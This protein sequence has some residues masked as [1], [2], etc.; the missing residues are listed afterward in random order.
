[1]A[2]IAFAVFFSVAMTRWL[3]REWRR[4]EDLPPRDRVAV[5]RALRRGEDVGERRLA[6]AVIDLADVIRQRQERDRRY[7]WVVWLFGGVMLC[8]AL[9]DSLAGSTRSA[10]PWWALTGFWA[11]LL[12]WLPRRSASALARAERAES[13]ARRT[14]HEGR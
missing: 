4:A 13:L 7:R 1:V 12:A 5:L 8:L 11:V 9:Y 10:V 6:R 3:Q 14:L 2:A